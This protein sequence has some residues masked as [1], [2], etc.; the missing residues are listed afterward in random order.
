MDLD[1]I[2]ALATR[3]KQ[4]LHCSQ[5]KAEYTASLLA[6]EHTVSKDSFELLADIQAI[7]YLCSQS[8]R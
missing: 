1:R 4:R 5:Q 2:Y 7:H 3:V 8:I 6:L